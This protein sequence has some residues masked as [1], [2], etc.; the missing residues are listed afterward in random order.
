L[1][2]GV[3]MIYA[4]G[5]APVWANSATRAVDVPPHQRGSASA[6]L[7][8]FEMATGSAFAY[9]VS[10]FE[11]T[12]MLPSTLLMAFAS[13]CAIGLYFWTSQE[14]SQKIGQEGAS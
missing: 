10:L 11:M 6:V 5:L 2:Y 12:S 8:T 4:I 7:T 13:T 9:T 1:L 3:L 14:S